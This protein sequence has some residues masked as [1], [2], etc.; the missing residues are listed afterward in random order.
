[1]ENTL[2]Y[3]NE[4]NKTAK[5]YLGVKIK[6][7]INYFNRIKSQ[8][9]QSNELN[10]DDITPAVEILFDAC[11]MYNAIFCCTFCHK[12]STKLG[13]YCICTM[14]ACKKCMEKIENI[15]GHSLDIEECLCYSCSQLLIPND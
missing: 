14:A 10:I 11:T 9:V 8:M 1:M 3:L 13:F 7:N 4:K 5:I 2:D 6:L 12:F 15:C